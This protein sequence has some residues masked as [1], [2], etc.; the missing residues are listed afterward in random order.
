MGCSLLELRSQ[1]IN[2]PGCRSTWLKTPCYLIMVFSNHKLFS[3]DS[4]FLP[5]PLPQAPA[6]RNLRELCLNTRK[7]HLLGFGYGPVMEAQ[8]YRRSSCADNSL[9]V[10]IVFQVDRPRNQCSIPGRGDI[11]L[12]SLAEATSVAHSGFYPMGIGGCFPGGK[13]AESWSY[14]SLMLNWI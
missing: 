3:V 11:I 7:R 13:A 14:L 9:A 4:P 6:T 5:L 1:L 8:L 2:N 10:V 12:F